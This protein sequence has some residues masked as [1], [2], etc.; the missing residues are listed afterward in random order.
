V[1]LFRLANRHGLVATITNY[2]GIVTS[3][4]VPDRAGNLGDIV[5]GY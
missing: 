2:G 3:L 1:E 4:L 5:L